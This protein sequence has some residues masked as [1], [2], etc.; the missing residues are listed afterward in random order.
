M[1]PRTSQKST[2]KEATPSMT[3][4]TPSMTTDTPSMTTD[5]SS[6][7]TDKNHPQQ[8]P[9]LP[10]PYNINGK[11]NLKKPLTEQFIKSEFTEVFDGLGRFPGEPYK[12]RLKPD[13]IPA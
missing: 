11:V 4:D 7:T 2:R 5:T 1:G 13:A 12:L 9:R 10:L 3:T 6:R 8:Q